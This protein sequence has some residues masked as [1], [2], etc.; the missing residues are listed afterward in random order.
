[1]IVQS[2]TAEGLF[3]ACFFFS[4]RESETN[5]Q[6]RFVATHPAQLAE[7]IPG[8]NIERAIKTDGRVF[9]KALEMQVEGLILRGCERSRHGI[10]F[11]PDI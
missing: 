10:H 4:I 9:E 1:M 2:S 6:T 3:V 11:H 8:L 5:N 7:N